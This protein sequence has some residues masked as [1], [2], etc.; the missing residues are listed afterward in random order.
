[1]Y[2]ICYGYDAERVHVSMMSDEGSNFELFPVT[3]AGRE[4][5]AL[6]LYVRRSS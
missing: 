1:M 6:M 5:G 3:R 2:V 4:R